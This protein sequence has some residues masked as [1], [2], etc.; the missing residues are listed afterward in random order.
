MN[1]IVKVVFGTKSYQRLKTIRNKHTQ[2]INRIRE[3]QTYINKWNDIPLS[4]TWRSVC[5]ILNIQ[6]NS[7]A[8]NLV[9]RMCFD[10]H[11]EKEIAKYLPLE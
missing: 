9:W 3:A 1:K 2:R 10:L 7:A 11:D 8:Y 6:A 4:Q 5:R